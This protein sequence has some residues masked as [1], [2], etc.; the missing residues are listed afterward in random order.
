VQTTDIPRRTELVE[1]AAGLAPVLCAN[2]L[3]EERNACLS[4]ESVEAMTAAGIF[5]MRVPRRYGGYECD[6]STLLDVGIELGRANGAAAFNVAAWWIMD[7][8]MGFFPDEVQDE[9]FADPDTRVCG[10]QTVAGK[11]IPA[12]GGMVV[13]GEWAFNSGATHSRWKLLSTIL[14]SPTAEPEPVM[15]IVPMSQLRIVSDWDVSALRGTGSVRTVAEDLF[16]PAVRTLRF[17]AVAAGESASKLNAELP[18]FRAPIVGAVAATSAGKLIGMARAA[19]DAFLDRIQTR[20]ISTTFYE[21]QADAPLTHLQ[22]AEATL[23]TDEA[24][25]HGRKIAALVDAKA[26]T[27]EPWTI[28]DRAYARAVAGRVPQ[29]VAEAVDLLAGACGASSLYLNDPIQRIRRDVRAIT[30]HAV[31]MP[32]TT[33]ELYGRVLCGL[34]PNTFFI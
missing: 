19:S 3:V 27:G 13:N 24:E 21:R 1:R 26:L 31:H 14:V 7:W 2:A 6:T 23:K 18:M 20:T 11:A 15:A 5:R 8:N 32:T 22:V 25:Y 16:V 28:Q 12:D 4:D 29:L 10:T 17:A 34:P 33:L 9:V 30:L